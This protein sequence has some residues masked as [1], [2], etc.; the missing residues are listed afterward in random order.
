M[1]VSN[2]SLLSLHT[3]DPDPPPARDAP[4]KSTLFCPDCGHQSRSDG[5]WNLVESA[6]ETR[7]LCPECEYTVTS[8][9]LADGDVRRVLGPWC[10]AWQTWEESVRIWQR[11]LRRAPSMD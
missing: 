8:R 9:R 1:G 11:F 6:R 3:S 4:A 5:D 10:F 7:Y 2:V